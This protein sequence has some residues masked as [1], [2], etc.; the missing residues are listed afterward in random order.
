MAEFADENMRGSQFERV[1]LSDALFRHVDMSNAQIAGAD[2]TGLRIRGADLIN[3]DISGEINNLRVNGIN[4]VPLI[5]AELN[6]R[7]PE[8]VKM[9]ATTPA[10]FREAWEILERLWAQT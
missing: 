1:D 2:L 4:V 5:E 3:V 8:R 6:R 10:E 9:S 7:Y